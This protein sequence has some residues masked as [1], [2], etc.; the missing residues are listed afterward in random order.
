MPVLD[1]GLENVGS[2]FRDLTPVPPRFL[3]FGL[4]SE[5]V[6]LGSENLVDGFIR[7]ELEWFVSGVDSK[8]ITSLTTLEGN[9]SNITEVGLGAGS[10]VGSDLYTRDLSAIGD[11]DNTFDVTV[12][13]EMRIRRPET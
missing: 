8:A 3:E 4:G 2:F 12:S 7:K 5:T 10:E 6:N 1:N 11:K 9:G 13:L